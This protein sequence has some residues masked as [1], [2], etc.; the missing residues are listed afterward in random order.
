MD[1]TKF[2]DICVTAAKV[3]HTDASENDCQ[4]SLTIDGIDVL[5]ELDEEAD[6]MHCYVDLGDANSHERMDVCEQLLALNLRTHSNHHGSYAF[7]PSSGRAI[8]CANLLD[9]ANLDGDELAK[10]LRYYVEETEEARQ[11]V[12]GTAMKSLGELFHPELA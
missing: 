2:H 3:L 6:A 10:M 1:H 12:N 8:F 4:C 11:I 7:E 5:I 9:A